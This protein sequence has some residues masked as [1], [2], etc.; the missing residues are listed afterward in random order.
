MFLY[1]RTLPLRAARRPL[2]IRLCE[3]HGGV[4]WAVSGWLWAC[5][6]KIR[7]TGK[8]VFYSLDGTGEDDPMRS[9]GRAIWG[10]TGA[11]FVDRHAIRRDLEIGS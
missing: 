10:K 3:D 1:R 5:S 6:R 9:G 4:L 7:H 2:A 8:F 11:E